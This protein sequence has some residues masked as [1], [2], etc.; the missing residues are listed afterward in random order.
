MSYYAYVE[1]FIEYDKS[2]NV[3]EVASRFEEELYCDPYSCRT[4]GDHHIEICGG[5]NGYNEDA[6]FA[7]FGQ[8]IDHTTAGEI[9]YTGEDYI[10]NWR[11]QF[12][13]DT[14]EWVE[15]EGKVVYDNS[16]RRIVAK[17]QPKIIKTIRIADGL[18]LRVDDDVEEYLDYP[19][20]P[21]K[22]FSWDA[23]CDKLLITNNVPDEVREALFIKLVCQGFL[24]LTDAYQGYRLVRIEMIPPSEEEG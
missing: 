10:T 19:K 14:H 21:T 8:Y 7:I 12:D 13:E 4:Y 22:K 24:D 15:Q 3:D 2:V 23:V 17:Q 6:L 16:E 18:R 9:T 5:M 20:D 11:H 1:G